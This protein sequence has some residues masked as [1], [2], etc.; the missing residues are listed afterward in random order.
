MVPRTVIRRPGPCWE[1]GP[2]PTEVTEVTYMPGDGASWLKMAKFQEYC[3]GP[4]QGHRTC[5][6]PNGSI[7]ERQTPRRRI[8]TP[9]TATFAPERLLCRA[10]SKDA[11]C[12]YM[13]FTFMVSRTRGTCRNAD[14]GIDGT[15]PLFPPQLLSPLAR[16]FATP[17]ALWI[18]HRTSKGHWTQPWRLHTTGLASEGWSRRFGTPGS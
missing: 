2:S 10:V 1:G 11:E 13:T 5:D 12:L 3:S 6:S 9:F 4:L 8:S 15:C 7:P 14:I 16:L 17:L 18:G